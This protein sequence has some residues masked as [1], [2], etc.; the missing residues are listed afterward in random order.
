M[1]RFDFSVIFFKEK[2]LLQPTRVFKYSSNS[3]KKNESL[4]FMNDHIK[5]FFAFAP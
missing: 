2:S 3:D 4:V 1:V 5:S